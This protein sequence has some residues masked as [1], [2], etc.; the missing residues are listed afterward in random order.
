MCFASLLFDVRTGMDSIIQSQQVQSVGV[1]LGYYFQNHRLMSY[2]FILVDEVNYQSRTGQ[3]CNPRFAANECFERVLH[4]IMRHT[5]ISQ[6][7]LV[8]TFL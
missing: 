5:I 7:G 1:N 8:V 3:Y 6:E 2:R 4:D